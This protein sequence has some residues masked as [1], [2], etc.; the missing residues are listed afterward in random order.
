MLTLDTVI[1]QLPAGQRHSQLFLPGRQHFGRLL[2]RLLVLPVALSLL[3][4]LCSQ[5]L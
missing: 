2:Y 5:R 3:F 4:Q 1:C